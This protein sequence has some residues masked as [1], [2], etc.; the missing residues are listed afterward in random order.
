M[1]KL[2]TVL[3]L[4][5]SLLCA[6]GQGG[7]TNSA[8]VNKGNTNNANVSRGNT[9]NSSVSNVS[10]VSAPNSNTP[11]TQPSKPNISNSRPA[12]TASAP[13]T[14]PTGLK[15]KGNKNSKVYHLPNCPDYSK[16]AEKNAV[17]FDT[18]EDAEK[19]GYRL[20][21]NCH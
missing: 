7:S 11:T 13:T 9:N 20:A 17:M 3:F 4:S 10:N 19:A 15:I 1:R 2:T 5:I 14:N 8:N 16:I 12:N 6:C 18:K 21:K